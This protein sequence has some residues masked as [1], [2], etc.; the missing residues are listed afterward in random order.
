MFHINTVDIWE[1]TSLTKL[2]I[3]YSRL[4]ESATGITEETSS[5]IGESDQ[6]KS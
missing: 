2:K 3:N 6:R 1:K 5:R 4:S